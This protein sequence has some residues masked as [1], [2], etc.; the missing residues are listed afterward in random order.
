MRLTTLLKNPADWMQGH[1]PHSD[2]VMTSRIRLARNL[3]S[4]PFPGWASERKRTELLG[5]VRPVVSGLMV[6]KDGYDEEYAN[7]NKMRKQVLVER[8]LVSREHAAR[9]TGCAVVIDRR[10]N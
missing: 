8:H 5:I 3:R 10:Q 1:G 6:M 7:L 2:V 4:W 9:S